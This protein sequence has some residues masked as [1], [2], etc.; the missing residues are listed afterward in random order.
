MCIFRLFRVHVKIHRE[1]FFQHQWWT[2]QVLLAGSRCT[3]EFYT[4][5]ALLLSS[6]WF[7]QPNDES[8]IVDRKNIYCSNSDCVHSFFFFFWEAWGGSPPTFGFRG[9]ACHSA[10]Q[11]DKKIRRSCNRAACWISRWRRRRKQNLRLKA[12]GAAHPS[13]PPRHLLPLCPPKACD[14]AAAGTTRCCS[15]SSRPPGGAGDATRLWRSQSHV[16]ECRT[17]KRPR[18]MSALRPRGGSFEGRRWWRHHWWPL[19]RFLRVC[20]CVQACVCVCVRLF[21]CLNPFCSAAA[22]VVWRRRPGHKFQCK[23]KFPHKRKGQ[24]PLRGGG[25]V[26][27][28][29]EQGV[30]PAV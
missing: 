26:T 18:I 22:A 13:T 25:G 29:K 6:W 1:I 19:R 8:L 17:S 15:A 21:V 7:C 9:P 24:M 27:K 28:G 4:T 20:V 30:W 2:G 11:R 12:S 14:A 16:L 10:S 23:H 3:F 5:T